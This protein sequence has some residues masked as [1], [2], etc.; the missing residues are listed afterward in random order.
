MML[1]GK[2]RLL[3]RTLPGPA[4]VKGLFITRAV[5]TE[6]VEPTKLLKTLSAIALV[7]SFID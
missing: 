1:T 5:S 4:S 6:G 2:Y 3:G 7:F